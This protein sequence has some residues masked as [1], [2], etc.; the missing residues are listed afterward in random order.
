M[1]YDFT[2]MSN[3]ALGKATTSTVTNFKSTR[4][5]TFVKK[6][7][8]KFWE[9]IKLTSD[10]ETVLLLAG[11]YSSLINGEQKQWKE[12]LLHRTP[13]VVGK[14]QGEIVCSAGFDEHDKQP[15][16]GCAHYESGPRKEN[17]WYR[18]PRVRFNA[19]SLAFYHDDI[20]YIKNGKAQTKEDGKPIFIKQKC[21]GKTCVHCQP[22]GKPK[23]FG[24]LM[25]LVLTGT[26]FSQLINYNKRLHNS[27]A[28]CGKSIVINEYSCANCNEQLL[29]VANNPVSQEWLD[30]FVSTPQT[31]GK[32]NH[33]ALPIEGLDCGYDEKG[34]TKEVDDCPLEYPVRM[35]IFTTVISVSK[36]GE[37]TK[38]ALSFGEK[39][40]I[41]PNSRI[42]YV[43]PVAVKLSLEEI[44]DSAINANGGKLFDL[45]AEIHTVSLKD[46]ASILNI[47]NPY[48]NENEVG[49]KGPGIPI[50]PS[51]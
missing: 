3:L 16:V 23:I 10:Y 17:P 4:P 50:F 15:C 39:K 51:N 37:K 20:P 49:P 48:E 47:E 42:K 31:C 33:S 14:Q 32:C 40:S 18:Q 5:S 44:L 29:D 13:F 45:D 38:S 7:L 43:K 11:N 27:C 26:H 1:K 35:N 19:L 6:E 41:L 36:E 28:G 46:Q 34:E 24:R 22:Y 12:Y 9:D 30:K 8:N 25:K 21:G 2:S